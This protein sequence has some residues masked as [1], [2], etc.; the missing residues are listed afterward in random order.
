MPQCSECGPPLFYF[1]FRRSR[2]KSVS[3]PGKC[4]VF[5]P[6]LQPE[7]QTAEGWGQYQPWQKY[8]PG[9]RD[10]G[11]AGSCFN[12]PKT[13]EVP[14]VKNRKCGPVRVHSSCTQTQFQ[15]FH[16]LSGGCT[17]AFTLPVFEDTA[18]EPS[19]AWLGWNP[20][21]FP[22]CQPQNLIFTEPHRN[23]HRQAPD[24]PLF[25]VGDF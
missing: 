18:A 25:I 8:P 6:A 23:H 19:G 13:K 2:F 10:W 17:P 15:P 14:H 16:F 5:I 11:P 1:C 4:A 3:G 9:E 24:M 12:G 20:A 21:G 22:R 7:I